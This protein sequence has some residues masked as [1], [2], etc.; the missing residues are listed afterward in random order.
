MRP[1]AAIKP[2]LSINAMFQW[3]QKAPDEASHKR[4]MAIWLTH[5]GK[6]HAKQ[7]ARILGISVQA[8]WL[9]IRQYN[10]QGP[11]GLER[12]GR[13]GRRWGF[14]TPKQEAEILRPYV[15]K[16]RDGVVTKPSEI[17]KVIEDKLGKTVS[18]PYLYRLLQRHKWAQ[19]IAQSS[20]NPTAKEQTDNYLKVVRPWLRGS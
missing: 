19:I 12:T 2:H 16:L 15:R 10:E 1:P 6:L 17:K 20:P 13:G 3:L 14:L 5:T 8:V 18:M 4:R 9:W 11:S 7:V